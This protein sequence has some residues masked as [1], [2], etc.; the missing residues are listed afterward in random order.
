MRKLKINQEEINKVMSKRNIVLEAMG[1]ESDNSVIE[2]E[3]YEFV[4]EDSFSKYGDVVEVEI[5]PNVIE[6]SFQKQDL[7][8]QDL[9]NQPRGFFV[10]E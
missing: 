3:E 4:I 2:V 5:A 10:G 8:I 9:N 1:F 6:V 7:Y